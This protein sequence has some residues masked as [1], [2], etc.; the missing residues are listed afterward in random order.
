MKQAKI[1][2]DKDFQVGSIDRRIYGSFIEHLGRAVYGGIY[3]PGHETAD[4]E[5]YNKLHPEKMSYKTRIECL[6]N[7]KEIG[8]QTGCGFMVGSPY[9]TTHN[10][11][12]DLKFI[13]E[14]G[15][16]MCGIGPFIPHRATPF[17]AHPAGDVGLTCYLLSVVRLLCPNVLLPATTALQTLAEDGRE[18]GIRAGANVVMPNLSPLSV[19]KKYMLY[20]NKLSSGAEAAENNPAE[21]TGKEGG[22]ENTQAEDQLGG[23]IGLG[24]EYGTHGDGEVAVDTDVKPFHGVADDGSA[25]GLFHHRFV[26]DI[27]I[28]DLQAPASQNGAALSRCIFRHVGFLS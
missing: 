7:L 25:D 22:G 20:D 21:G 23:G 16:Q 15:P 1:T 19:R 28:I 12:K 13:E 14:F 17:A 5:H 24:E 3:E 9:Q 4:E 2:I 26:N 8:F 11:A 10:I 6:K 27:H 18:R